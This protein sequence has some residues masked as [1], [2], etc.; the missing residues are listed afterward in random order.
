MRSK[1]KF[2]TCDFCT[3][4]VALFSAIFLELKL[5]FQIDCVFNKLK[6]ISAQFF[7]QGFRICLKLNANVQVLSENVQRY[8][9]SQLVL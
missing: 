6:A 5:Q 4:F 3:I 1:G 2:L 8:L 9:K 7:P